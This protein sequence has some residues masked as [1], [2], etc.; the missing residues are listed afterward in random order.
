[1]KKPQLNY[2]KQHSLMELLLIQLEMNQRIFQNKNNEHEIFSFLCDDS[3]TKIT[4]GFLY[5]IGKK[6]PRFSPTIPFQII[7]NLRFLQSGLFI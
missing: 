4:V 5:H 7:F 3:L 1:M 2:Y 6:A